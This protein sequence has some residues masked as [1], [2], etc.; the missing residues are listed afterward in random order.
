MHIKNN[1]NDNSILD[2]SKNEE[3]RIVVYCASSSEID[4]VYFNAASNLGKILAE[5]NISCITGAGNAGLMGELN[6]SVIK[7][8]GKAIG[9]IPQFMVDAGWCHPALSNVII[10]SSLHERKAEMARL[11]NAVIAL[12]GGIGTLEELAEIITWKQLG[13]YKGP[14]VLLNIKSFYDPLLEMLNRM[15][16]QSF[17]NADHKDLWYVVQTPQEA[18]DYLSIVKINELDK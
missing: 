14:I 9:V 4:D 15:I 18:L 8:G 11:S 5:N 7:F 17:L 13:I 6:N 3:T 12:P 1:S 2:S 10:T 16:E